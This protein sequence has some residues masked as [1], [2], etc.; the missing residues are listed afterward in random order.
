M[1]SFASIAEP[2]KDLLAE[3][4]VADNFGHWSHSALSNHFDP[5]EDLRKWASSIRAKLKKAGFEPIQIDRLVPRRG[6]LAIELP[7]ENIQIDE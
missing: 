2:L 5:G 3:Y 6:H 1:D 7:P 4:Q